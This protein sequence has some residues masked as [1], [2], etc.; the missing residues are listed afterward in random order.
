MLIETENTQF[1]MIEMGIQ[2]QWMFNLPGLYELM[3]GWIVEVEANLYGPVL[4]PTADKQWL[5]LFASAI[6]DFVSDGPAWE[7]T[8]HEAQCKAYLLQR[9]ENGLKR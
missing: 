7:F 5:N 4:L 6:N 8:L 2:P 3:T 1:T 9:G